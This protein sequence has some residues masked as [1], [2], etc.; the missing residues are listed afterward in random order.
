MPT[1]VKKVKGKSCYKVE[2]KTYNKKGKSVT[3]TH[4]NCSTKA[5]AEKQKVILDQYNRKQAIQKKYGPVETKKYK[6]RMKK[7]YG[8]K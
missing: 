6:K 3:N 1:S 8:K 4:A 7:K 2:T 5:K